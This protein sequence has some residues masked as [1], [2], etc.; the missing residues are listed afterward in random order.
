MKVVWHK[1]TGLSDL[2]QTWWE[3]HQAGFKPKVEQ[4]IYLR[5][6]HV[7]V[8]YS[9]TYSQ[10]SCLYSTF[11]PTQSSTYLMLSTHIQDGQMLS[12]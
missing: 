2:K 3:K 11:W 6:K 4:S 7:G 8:L 5:V 1:E 9:T 10:D 12:N